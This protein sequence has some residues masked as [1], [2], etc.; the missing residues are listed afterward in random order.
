M[1]IINKNTSKEDSEKAKQEALKA[2]KDS[3][4]GDYS[5]QN[6]I[7]TLQETINRFYPK[8]NDDCLQ[9][10]LVNLKKSEKNIQAT[11]T[12]YKFDNNNIGLVYGLGVCRH[13]ATL[14]NYLIKNLNKQNIQAYVL[15][16]MSL[17]LGIIYGLKMATTAILT[18]KLIRITQSL[19]NLIMKKK[20]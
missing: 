16:T 4:K 18:T 10:C 7:N 17:I 15:L 13:M 14:V 6:V 8:D 1:G 20:Y 2:F 3:L 19:S 5:E 9:D 12:C 11:K